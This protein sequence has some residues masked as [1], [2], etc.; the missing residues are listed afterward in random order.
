MQNTNIEV[1]EF[2]IL[3]LKRLNIDLQFFL[4][5]GLCNLAAEEG[6]SLNI[7]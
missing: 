2:V 6:I 5:E 7:A 4:D 3:L 1:S